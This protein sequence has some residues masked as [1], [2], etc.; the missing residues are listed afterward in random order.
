MN[1]QFRAFQQQLTNPLKYRLYMISKLPA[2]YFCG[3]RI[4][5][6]DERGSIVSVKQKWFN[7][8]PFHSIYFAVL[9]MA[10]EMS[11]GLLCMG[12]IYKR[13]PAVS[14]L[15]TK[16]EG[17]FLKKA[18]G[19]ILFA[20]NDGEAIRKVVDHVIESNQAE[21]IT[22]SST[23]SNTDNEVVAEFFITWSFKGRN[24]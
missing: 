5:Q 15:V 22:C 8:N 16:I 4:Q 24:K 18:T 17:R 14:M 20:C 7:K 12:N 9:S 23:G 11:T 10:A 13:T 6:F 19:N 21:T 3:I 1:P 2:A